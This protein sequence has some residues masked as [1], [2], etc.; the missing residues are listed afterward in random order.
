MGSRLSGTG[1]RIR[2]LR[3]RDFKGVDVLLEWRPAL[4]LFGRNN[5][6]KSNVLEGIDEASEGE[7]AVRVIFTPCSLGFE[8]FLYA[9]R[10]VLGYIC[11]KTCGSR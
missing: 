5:A 1:M 2:T 3:L 10:L 8:S 9:H 7:V 4:V 6:G 11:D